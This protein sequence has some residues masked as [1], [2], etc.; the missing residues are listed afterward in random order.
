LTSS[1]ASMCPPDVS[2]L[3]DKL[4]RLGVAGPSGALPRGPGAGRA[5]RE[6]VEVVRARY[7]LDHRYGRWSLGEALDLVA[8]GPELHRLGP[9]GGGGRVEDRRPPPRTV[10]LDTETTGLAG[11]TG[12]YAFLVG[13]AYLEDG[14][15][16]VEQFLLRRLSA[17]GVLLDAV[18]ERL[19]EEVHLVTYNGLRFDWPILE[20][21]FVLARREPPA[22]VHTDLIRPARR[23]WHRVLGT[24]RLSVLEAEVLEASRGEDVPGWQIP[25]LYLH[26]LHSDDRGVLDPVLRHNRADLLAL[27]ALHGQVVHALRDP[28]G[29]GTHLDWEG[30]G[31]LL[32]RLGEHRRAAACFERALRETWEPRARW[33]TLRRLAGQERLLGEVA[34]CRHRW[35][36]EA[37]LWTSPDRYRVQ[38]LEELARIRE[39]GGD[40]AGARDAASA[41]LEVAL[42][43]SRAPGGEALAPVARR[44]DRRLRRLRGA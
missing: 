21:R 5:G 43:V 22:T 3:R 37:L 20:A 16:V 10:W 8:K 42:S 39:A 38:V 31:V 34:R 2:P 28:D 35:E 30:A 4:R 1:G 9:D 18:R 25:G 33:R 12:T 14:A 32:A 27:V 7:G 40:L 6:G 23:L 44:L 29:A 11:G 24:H 17:E 41:A 19:G 26:Y 15:V 36:E 13:V